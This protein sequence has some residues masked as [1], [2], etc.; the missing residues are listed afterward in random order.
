M[1][2]AIKKKQRR[3]GTLFIFQFQTN[4]NHSVI[5]YYKEKFPNRKKMFAVLFTELQGGQTQPGL[6]IQ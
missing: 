1:I 2:I 5:F 3:K 6:L 4:T